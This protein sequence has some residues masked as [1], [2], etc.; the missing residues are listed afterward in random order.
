MKRIFTGAGLRPKDPDYHNNIG[1][2]YLGK[3]KYRP[4]IVEFKKAIELKPNDSWF[5]TNLSIAQRRLGNPEEALESVRLALAANPRDAGAHHTLGNTRVALNRLDEAMV[6]YLKALQ[7]DSTSI[8]TTKDLISCLSELLT[9]TIQ[10]PEDEQELLRAQSD[11][12]NLTQDMTGQFIESINSGP[13][14][15][16]DEKVGIV[17]TRWL[18]DHLGRIGENLPSSCPQRIRELLRLS[19]IAI[20]LKDI[21]ESVRTTRNQD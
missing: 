16:T 5:L 2:L 18:V 12:E 17:F 3:G 1:G 19:F 10:T 4:A 15:D 9:I 7:I 20:H 14:G 11:L 13:D 21:Q 8:M 6:A